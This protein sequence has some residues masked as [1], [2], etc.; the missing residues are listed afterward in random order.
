MKFGHVFLRKITEFIATRCHI[1]RL[2]YIKFDFG[3]GSTTDPAGELTVLPKTSC[4]IERGLHIRDG[5]RR[6]WEWERIGVV[7]RKGGKRR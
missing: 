7:Q 5:E 6:V 4:W 2:K 1:L 3:W